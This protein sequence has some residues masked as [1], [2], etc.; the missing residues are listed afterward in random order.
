MSMSRE[1]NLFDALYDTL[2]RLETVEGRKYIILVSSGRD[3]FSKRTLDQIL[4]KVQASKEIEIY[5]IGT[6]QALRNWA[7]SHGYLQYLCD[8]TEL[9]CRTTFHQS[10]NHI[11]SFTRINGGRSE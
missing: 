3:T 5:S 2:D 1:T 4:K 7:D 6:G 10:D 11:Q 9:N 8:M